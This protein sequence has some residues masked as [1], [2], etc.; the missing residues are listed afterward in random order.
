[1]SEVFRNWA[2]NQVATPAE[3]VVVVTVAAIVVEGR[4]GGTASSGPARLT[5]VVV[6]APR[7]VE[8]RAAMSAPATGGEGLSPTALPAEDTAA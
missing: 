2:G 8:M 4:L 6:S 5:V 7:V 3:V 1:M